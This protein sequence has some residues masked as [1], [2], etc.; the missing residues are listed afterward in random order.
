MFPHLVG[1]S[2][3]VD[4]KPYPLSLLSRFRELYGD[5]PFFPVKTICIPGRTDPDDRFDWLDTYG[6][7]RVW[8]SGEQD[9]IDFLACPR[10]S[11]DQ[12][13]LFFLRAVG[14][15]LGDVWR[16]RDS[17][18]MIP[19]S[20]IARCSLSVATEILKTMKKEEVPRY[21]HNA[22]SFFPWHCDLTHDEVS[23]IRS[24]DDYLHLCVSLA[25]KAQQQ[26]SLAVIKTVPDEI[27]VARNRKR[28]R[29]LLKEAAQLLDRDLQAATHK[30]RE[31]LN[32]LER[33]DASEWAAQTAKKPG[34]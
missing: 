20:I 3:R 23:Q 1:K 34:E 5:K 33:A 8:R 2:W 19:S 21:A 25:E 16:H 14:H 7:S 22:T 11:A 24:L 26:G 31:A 27:A 12:R 15:E 29:T 28:G 10:F 17:D 30:A 13:L 9:T 4:H 18:G 32:L 6:G